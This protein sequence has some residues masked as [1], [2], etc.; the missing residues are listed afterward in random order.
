M[1]DL[2]NK[3]IVQG[4]IG[5]FPSSWVKGG[6]GSK[7]KLGGRSMYKEYSTGVVFTRII[8]QGSIERHSS[9]A[10]KGEE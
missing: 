6:K 9:V 10:V 7:L 1:T 8:S 4:S 2:G 3:G 5:M